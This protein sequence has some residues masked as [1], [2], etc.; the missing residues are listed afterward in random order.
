MIFL[1]A[2]TFV[3]T[4]VLLS[5]L[6]VA[7]RTNRPSSGADPA[8]WRALTDRPYLAVT[9]LNAI[10]IVLLQVRASRNIDTVP[11][12]GRAARRAGLLLGAACLV[13]AAAGHNGAWIAAAVI[14]V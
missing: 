7:R 9:V 8:R 3:L 13:Y 12:A 6:P 10:M 2:L 14:V 5:R 11:A 4:A 1:D